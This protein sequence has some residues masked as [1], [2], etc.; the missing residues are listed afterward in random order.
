MS[1]LS[2]CPRPQGD[3]LE[4]D[5]AEHLVARS[6]EAA[7]ERQ[8]VSAAATAE[9][10]KADC[11]ESNGEEYDEEEEEGEGEGEE[12]EEV[13]MD[14]E[15]MLRMLDK[16]EPPLSVCQRLLKD[17]GGGDGPWLVLSDSQRASL[18][19]RGFAVLDGLAAASLA[20]EAYKEASF[21]TARAASG[22]LAP[23]HGGGGGGGA[24][25]INGGC[26]HGTREGDGAFNEEGL[27]GE[28]VPAAAAPG[29]TGYVKSVRDDLTAFVSSEREAGA[30]PGGADA[31]AETGAV[32]RTLA[33]LARL[34]ED[35]GRM[36][37]LRGRVEHQLAVYP[38]GIGARYERHRDAYPD[39]GDGDY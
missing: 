15:E 33:I 39:D 22:V 12:E 9:C 10:G 2:G 18:S 38:A 1:S 27:K 8:C 13:V 25:G 19:Q 17:D 21:A 23:A 28:G 3:R 7:E 30:A 6:A 16:M 14:E 26:G 32:G 29:V 35:L 37:R 34:G 20:A 4:H 36:V 24:S 11:N 5:P 31:A